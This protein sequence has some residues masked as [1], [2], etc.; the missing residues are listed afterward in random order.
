MVEPNEI[1]AH[2]RRL[3]DALRKPGI[4]HAVLDGQDAL[5]ELLPNGSMGCLGPIRRN[6]ACLFS[7]RPGMDHPIS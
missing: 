3:T 6:R 7:Q 4:T 1:P 2:N 5:L